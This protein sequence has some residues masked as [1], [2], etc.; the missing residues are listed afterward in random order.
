MLPHFYYHP[1]ML[2]YDFGDRHPLKP[3]R[4]R[5]AIRLLQAIGLREIVDP[6]IGD[7]EDLLRVHDADYVEAVEMMSSGMYLPT[8]FR[9]QF[10]FSSV[11]NPPFEGMFEASLAY[12][13]GAVA[14]AKAVRDG[15][16]LAFNMSGG[17]HHGMRAR[18]TGFCIFNDP[19]ICCHILR[20]R[21]SRVAYVDI[22]VHHGDGV[23]W[24][25]FDDP[26]VMT[27]SIHE[28]P[29][30]L[31]PGTGGYHE[32]GAECTSVNVPLEAKSTGEVW[33]W[34]FEEGILP[35]LERFRPEAIV[36][37]M[38]TDPHFRDPLG[39]LRV[40]A[41]EWLGAVQ[42]IRDLGLPIVAM[43]GGGYNLE[44]VPRMWAAACLTLSGIEVPDRLPTDLAQEWN[45]V[46][47]FDLD[48]P[49]PRDQGRA[50]AEATVDWLRR[51]L[52]PKVPVA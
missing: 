41:Q 31:F 45:S 17:L 43:G 7:R 14:A 37:Q 50:F 5:R 34:A 28:D 33:L 52:H 21:F 42:R 39:H 3:E 48:P 36:L 1:R 40:T 27:C 51:E 26:T 18:A 19:A 9:A 16:P 49:E 13:G 6:G 12:V 29:R 47:F 20:E 32:T 46:H 25:W 30:T 4:L 38:G 24:I 11:D 10:G 35:A 8:G 2:D 23:Q 44:T 15:A 22:D